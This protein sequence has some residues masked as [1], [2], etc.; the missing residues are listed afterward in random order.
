MNFIGLPDSRTSYAFVDVLLPR[1][2]QKIPCSIFLDLVIVNEIK[3][4]ENHTFVP[5]RE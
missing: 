2:Y 3:I 1:H 5:L 4:E